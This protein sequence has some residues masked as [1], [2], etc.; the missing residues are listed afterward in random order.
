MSAGRIRE[1]IGDDPDALFDAGNTFRGAG[2]LERLKALFA[3]AIERGVPEAY[4]NLAY[5]VRNDGN[6]ELAMRLLEMGGLS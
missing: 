2:D 6:E 1:S 3:A 4:L 5:L